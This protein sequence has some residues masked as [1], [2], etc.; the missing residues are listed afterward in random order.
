[1]D[2]SMTFVATG[3]SF[4]TR[5]VPP[6]NQA[7][8]EIASLIQSAE[9]RFT[10]FEVTA[11]N[12]E[13]YPGAVSGGTWARTSPEVLEDLK[14]YGFNLVAW[15]NNHTLDYTYG[16]L[17]AT[18]KY[19]NQYGFVHAGV[20]S[21]LAYASEPRYLE[22]NSGRVALISATS[23]FHETHI[24]GE[25]RPDMMGRPGINPLRFSTIHKIS[26]EKMAQLKEIADTVDLNAVENLKMKEGFQ[27][28][29]TDDLYSFGK[30]LFK[31]DVEEG[32]ITIPNQIDLNRIRNAI[33]EAKRQ[34]DYVLVSIH[35]H[36][37][38]G[39]RKELPAEFLE[40]FSRAC[41]DEGAHAVIGHGPHIVRGIEIYK[42][43]PIF[44]SLGNFIFQNDTV[45]H[46]PA[47][48][49]EK[50]G[51]DH[52]NNVADAFDRR[53][54]NNTAGFGAI[55]DIWLSF[56]PTW[57]MKDGVLEEILLYPIEL[58][59]KEPRSIRGWPA[60]DNRTSVLKKL[61]ELSEPYGT[62]IEIEEG[63]GRIYVKDLIKS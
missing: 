55:E 46:L 44:Y 23:T 41:I 35:A 21:N 8:E 49:Y 1:M 15:A 17:V 42:S 39:E 40:M 52:K 33:S 11:H 26:A 3:D 28:P 38:K 4:I 59:F 58:G 13:G 50:Y 10:N 54:R 45:S 25:Q 56:I 36:E 20:G 47:D 48:F 29:R 5:R 57:K 9:V 61:Q 19:L 18:E 16:G 34:A 24:A 22:T 7:F 32:Q 60:L 51:L 31:Q 6:G 53:S 63:I 14:N 43:K 2:K 12:F 37:M 27:L 62:K 30:Y